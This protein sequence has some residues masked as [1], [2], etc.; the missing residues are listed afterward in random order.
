M[1][2]VSV[3]VCVVDWELKYKYQVCVI[4]PPL[5]FVVKCGSILIVR[6]A[7]AQCHDNY[8]SAN[9]IRNVHFFKARFDLVDKNLIPSRQD[10]H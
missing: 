4:L 8:M 5:H 3:C 7:A 2:F 9:K 1:G 10:V 6:S